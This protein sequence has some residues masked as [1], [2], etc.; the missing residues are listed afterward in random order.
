MAATCALI[1]MR[2]ALS[3]LEPAACSA[4]ITALPRES[5]SERQ[6]LSMSRAHVRAAVSTAW[7][8]A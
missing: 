2:Y 5:L 7:T 6:P 3:V 4:R 8:D 1:S